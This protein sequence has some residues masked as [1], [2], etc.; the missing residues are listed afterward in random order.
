V[1]A[2]LIEAGMNVARINFS[3]GSHETHRSVI[4]RI[5][6]E[7]SRLGRCVAILQDLQGPKI[8]V[9]RF[10]QGQIMLKEGSPFVL[11][12]RNIQGSQREGQVGYAGFHR[13]VNVG[14][15]VLLD[16][17]NLML[18]VERIVDQDVHCQVRF[19]GVLKDHKGLNLPNSRLS[20]EALTEK[21]RQDLAFGLDVGVDF[22]A[23]SFVQR[24]EDL[25]LAKKTMA[26]F[27]R[28]VPL[29]AKIEKPQA[30]R[31]LEALLPHCQ[32]IMIAR[33][34][35]GVECPT[36]EVPVLQ[37]RMVAQCNAAGIPVITAT[38]MLESMIEHPR[39]TRAEASDVANAVLDGSDA[40][41]LSGETAAG[42]FPVAAVETMA[43]I[44]EHV[45]THVGGRDE[46]QRR[47]MEGTSWSTPSALSYSAVQAAEMVNAK[48]IV[49]LTQS[50]ST[51]LEL[52]R[53]RPRV[54]ILALTNTREAYH[55]LALVWGVEPFAVSEL[56]GNMDRTV[57]N[58][59]GLLM[60]QGRFHIG[61]RLVFTAGLPFSEKRTTNMLRIEEVSSTLATT[62]G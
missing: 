50:G 46:R 34:D 18:L 57:R 9:G 39:P 42:H 26:E 8:R 17:G 27:G 40:V 12:T 47:R 22:V 29:I 20:V 21:D 13:D 43:R 16:D 15:S 41:M 44:I 56:Q 24:P 49:C 1:I 54:P 38:Q 4:K 53:F 35:L 52:A 33:G 10:P 5:R 45:E 14:D 7:A 31:E 37:K 51:A 61:D 59:M 3:H 2:R 58:L 62:D 23:L 32:G 30:V 6:S 25:M 48:A 55:R 19:G 60:A 11:T 36:E 28:V